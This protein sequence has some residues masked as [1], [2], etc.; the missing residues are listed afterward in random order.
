MSYGWLIIP[1]MAVLGASMAVILSIPDKWDHAV[2]IGT[3]GGLPILR[4]ENGTVWM[5]VSSMRVYR[6]EDQDK[7]TCR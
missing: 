2:A 1:A 4:Q 6:I 3:C 7:L 5:R